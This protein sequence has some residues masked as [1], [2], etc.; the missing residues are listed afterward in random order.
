MCVAIEAGVQLRVIG[1]C[2]RITLDRQHTRNALGVD[3]IAELGRSVRSAIADPTVRLLVIDHVGPVFCSGIDL[4][5]TT[6]VAVHDQPVVA[7]P[8]LLQQLWACPK[9]VLAAVDGKVRAGGIGLLAACDITLATPMSDFA[10]TEVRLGLVPAVISVPL[11]AR[12]RPHA[13]RELLLTGEVV[14]AGRAHRDG[15]ID[16]LTEDLAGE[17]ERYTAV[18]VRCAPGAF[19]ATK[20]LLQSPETADTLG[21]RYAQLAA[22]SAAAFAGEE[23]QEGIAAMRAHRSPAWNLGDQPMG[24]EDQ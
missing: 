16:T 6:D 4:T 2:A 20:A 10:A 21:R 15:L 3:T 1:P 18:F 24:R 23:G 8:A 5:A 12:M 9:P 17:V 22:T 13:A 7:F 19:A 14:D 11:M